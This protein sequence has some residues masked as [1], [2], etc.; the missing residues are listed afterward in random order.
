M[1]LQTKAE[2][3]NAKDQADQTFARLG[4]LGVDKFP[5]AIDLP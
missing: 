5:K 4:P 1:F 2:A 3:D